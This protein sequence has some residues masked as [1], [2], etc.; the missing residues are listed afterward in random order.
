MHIKRIRQ[1]KKWLVFTASRRGS[2]CP[3]LAEFGAGEICNELFPKVRRAGFRWGK[4]CGNHYPC[5]CSV[6]NDSYV[7]RKARKVVK[8]YG[9]D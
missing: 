8:D 7:S 6:Y 2:H 4:H 9:I 5:P 3:F 1:I